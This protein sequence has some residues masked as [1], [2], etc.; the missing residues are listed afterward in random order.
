MTL[1]LPQKQH[2][3]FSHISARFITVIILWCLLFPSCHVAQIGPS[4]K[5][6][7]VQPNQ[8]VIRIKI[9]R[10]GYNFHRP[11]QRR[12]SSTHTAIGVVIEGPRVLV[13]SRFLADNRYIE[14][15]RVD[16]RKKSGAKIEVIDYETNLAVLQP[17]HPRFLE[18]IQPL[19]LTTDAFQGDQL[20]VWQVNPN[21]GVTPALGT[22]TSIELTRYPFSDYFLTY[23]LNSSLQYRFNNFT[24]PVVKN[25]KLAG[26]LMRYDSKAQTIDV[27]A[28][29][30]IENFIKD[31]VDGNYLGFPMSGIKIA[32]TE[33]PQLRRYV[34]IAGKPGG[35]YVEKVIKNSAAE[36]AGIRKGDIIM[37]IAGFGLD[38]R[39]NYD[40]PIYG[41]VSLSHLIRCEYYVGNSITF[42][43]F[44]TGKEFT[45]DVILDHI[46]PEDYLVPPYIVDKA[47]RYYILGGL[48]FQE[49]SG[50]YL[51]EYGKEWSAKA[52]VHLAYYLANQDNFAYDGRKKIVFLSRV[53][54]TSYTIGY[55]ELSHLVI[56]RINNKDIFKLDDIPPALE[57]PKN[58]FHKLEFEQR[59]KVIYIDTL[60]IP[61]INKQI[62]ER[63]NLP[64]LKNMGPR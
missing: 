64:A 21:G 14:L 36:R 49:L 47:P 35:V 46:Q 60:E 5:K 15:E 10:Q 40:H 6:I 19:K 52:P 41:K 20:A 45:V 48:V 13:T 9:T 58:G 59:P 11:W 57:N 7:N 25:D 30:V 55:N 32:P 16:N 50:T 51:R 28:A 53:L 39:G 34:G 43:I 22:I 23:R 62:R 38:S 37:E 3:K 1:A 27:I 44:R 54:P 17:I 33:D 31:A 61:K 18:N 29:P 8:P 4:E 63:Y 26:L 2:L 56:K 24:L 42:R 12:A